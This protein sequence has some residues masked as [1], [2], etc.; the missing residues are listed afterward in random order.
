MY[1]FQFDSSNYKDLLRCYLKGGLSLKIESLIREASEEIT[2]EYWRAFLIEIAYS[3]G[4]ANSILN[5]E[6]SESTYKE[7]KKLVK[8]NL[9]KKIMSNS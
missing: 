7:L 1:N 5:D 2:L 4:Y 3:V 6:M 8:E 9:I